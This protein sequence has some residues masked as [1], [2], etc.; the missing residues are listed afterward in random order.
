MYALRGLSPENAF[1]PNLPHVEVELED[2]NYEI[3]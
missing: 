1:N 3:L 2:T